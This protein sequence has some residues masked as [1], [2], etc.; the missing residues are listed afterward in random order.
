MPEMGGLEAA[1]RIRGQLHLQ[2]RP[3]QVALTAKAMTSDRD[4][5]PAAGMNDHVAKPIRLKPLAAALAIGNLSGQLLQFKPIRLKPLAAARERAEAGLQVANIFPAM[6]T[7]RA[8]V[9]GA[10]G[11]L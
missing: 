2:E 6:E 5:C 1:R 9:A 7:Q 8:R 10:G 11:A 3:W 4:E